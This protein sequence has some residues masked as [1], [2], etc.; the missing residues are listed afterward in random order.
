MIP[1]EL[2]TLIFLYLALLL[3]TILGAWVLSEWRQRQRERHA[4][5]SVLR[6]TL[7][8]F[9]FEDRTET[10]LPPCPQ[11]GTL[12]ERLRFSRL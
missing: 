2:S 10:R 7:C 12:N 5:R 11:C 8:G 9:A 4:F 1:V 3:A 6:C